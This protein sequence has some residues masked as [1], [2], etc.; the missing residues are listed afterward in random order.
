MMNKSVV[1]SKTEEY[2]QQSKIGGILGRIDTLS[3]IGIDHD[4]LRDIGIH[5]AIVPLSF[6]GGYLYGTIGNNHGVLSL[7][8]D[9]GY[10]GHHVGCIGRE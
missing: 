4:S 9:T 2:Y 5:S 8:G 3:R 1:W 10:N 6:I 7:I